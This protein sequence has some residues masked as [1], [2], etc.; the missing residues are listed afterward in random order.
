M[1]HP[2]KTDQFA[3][4][5]I[6]SSSQMKDDGN[7]GF[8]SRKIC[9]CIACCGC[10]STDQITGVCSA[11]K[12]HRADSITSLD[13]GMD[14]FQSV[15]LN[16]SN[17]AREVTQNMQVSTFPK[18]IRSTKVKHLKFT[19][20]DQKQWDE[21]GKSVYSQI[22]PALCAIRS[23]QSVSSNTQKSVSKQTTGYPDKSTHFLSHEKRYIS[24]LKDSI[25]DPITSPT[26]FK[27]RA[28][29]SMI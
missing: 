8:F 29:V 17:S 14:E 9:H 28:N 13:A 20:N 19:D 27:E 24:Q 5:C 4:G 3:N 2:Y 15:A 22:K 7:N 6:S 1:A 10:S 26:G 16:C 18:V 12:R 11:L 25:T 21:T 23:A